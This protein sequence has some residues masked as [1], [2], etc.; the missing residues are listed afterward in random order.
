VRIHLVL[1]ALISPT[2]AFAEP[3]SLWEAELQLGY[4]VAR[5]GSPEMA[6][7]TASP[8][9]L[10]ALGAVAISDDPPALAFGGLTVETL[11]R[12]SVG[13]IA[14]AR[15][16]PTS[17]PVRLRGGGVWMFA[18]LTLWGAQGSAGACLSGSKFAVCGDLQL[19]AYFAGTG[20]PA[21]ETELQ[22]QFALGFVTK[23]GR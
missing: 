8:V 12:S 15:L 21:D 14:G 1:C 16:E 22:I 5:R 3:V 13:M 11:E 17:L 9:T 2:V 19:T 7:T 6:A 23:G 20:L 4:G 18:P 10:T